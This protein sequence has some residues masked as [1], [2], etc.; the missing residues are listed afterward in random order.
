MS[1]DQPAV[2]SIFDLYK[3]GAG[4]SSS[5]SIGTERAARRFLARQPTPPAS[6]RV[7]LFGSLAATGRGHLTDQG[8]RRALD[9]IPVEIVWDTDAGNLKHPNT[10][11]FDA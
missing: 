4:P 11:R 9:G 6:V 2:G 1:T 3:I 8:I 5:H 10:I 7:T